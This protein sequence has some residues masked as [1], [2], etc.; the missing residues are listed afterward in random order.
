MFNQVLLIGR[1]TRNP[2]IR[3]SGAGNKVANFSIAVD[4]IKK[5]EV[6][7]FKITA[8]GKTAELVEKYLTKGKKIFIQGVLRQNDY[9]DKNGNKHYKTDIIANRIIF[10]EK[11]SQQNNFNTP[12]FEDIKPIEEDDDLP[13]FEEPMPD[14]FPLDD[15]M[16]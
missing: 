1:L 16:R 10:L 8:F 11:K 6:D 9:T 13:S 2:E 7:F 5:D 4:R 3:I 15:E 14:F 12:E